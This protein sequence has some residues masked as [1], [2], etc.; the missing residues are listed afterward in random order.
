MT[1]YATNTD[2]EIIQL[3][4]HDS[5]MCCSR[6]VPFH[7]WQHPKYGTVCFTRFCS[8]EKWFL[9]WQKKIAE[10]VLKLMRCMFHNRLMNYGSYIYWLSQMVFLY[11]SVG[12]HKMSNKSKLVQVSQMSSHITQINIMNFNIFCNN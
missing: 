9:T 8:H 7:L 5:F 12:G 1:Q 10:L 6:H 3:T 11:V 2:F 4:S